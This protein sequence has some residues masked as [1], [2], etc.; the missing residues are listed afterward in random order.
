MSDLAAELLDEARVFELAALLLETELSPERLLE[1]L[2]EVERAM[3]RDR[4]AAVAKGPRV[5]DLD[6]L[7]Y[8]DEVI[9]TPE[10]RIPHPLMHQRKFVLQGLAA[11]LLGVVFCV[12]CVEATPPAPT[13]PPPAPLDGCRKVAAE[14]K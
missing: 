3:G 9:D 4:S 5:I 1:E 2:L 7:L 6:L 11:F 13:G 10:L 8:G 12:T 14:K